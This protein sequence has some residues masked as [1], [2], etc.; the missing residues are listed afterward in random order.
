MWEKQLPPVPDFVSINRSLELGYIFPKGTPG[1][2]GLS[3]DNSGIS[4]GRGILKGGI[5][6]IDGFILFVSGG[7]G[8]SGATGLECLR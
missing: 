2:A 3:V 5:F 1:D 4:W 7:G 8:I 6:L